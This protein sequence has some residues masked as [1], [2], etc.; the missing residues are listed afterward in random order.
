MDWN[1]AEISISEQAKLIGINRSSLYY[2]PVLPSA[3]EVAVKHRTDE[4]HTQFPFFDSRSIT[5]LLNQEGVKINRKST[6]SYA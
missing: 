4:I 3:E 1:D 2:K 6:A 5:Q